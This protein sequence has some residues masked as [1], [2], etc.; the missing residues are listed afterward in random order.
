MKTHRK[1]IL[2][3]C[4]TVLTGSFAIAE[5]A[6]AGPIGGMNA[7]TE[8]APINQ[9]EIKAKPKKNVGR[10]PATSRL[11]V[12]PGATPPAGVIA[13]APDHS[14]A[15]TTKRKAPI[16]AHLDPGQIL[17]M[18]IGGGSEVADGIAAGVMVT[19]LFH[20][21]SLFGSSLEVRAHPAGSSPENTLQIALLPENGTQTYEYEI[22]VGKGMFNVAVDAYWVDPMP[23][24][25]H[26]ELLA[27]GKQ[28]S[29]EGK[30]YVTL[31]PDPSWSVVP[32]AYYVI[33][34]RDDADWTFKG[35]TI[36]RGI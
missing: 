8:V 32:T 26:D 22:E 35:V 33:V 21:G 14:I 29:H 19:G 36:S 23:S 18:S 28:R 5:V 27:V 6:E 11:V 20:T 12:A 30:L 3:S 7:P 31:S 4:F 10:A 1:L 9:D 17:N 24:R 34:S 16:P 15:L 2:F 25:D 13:P